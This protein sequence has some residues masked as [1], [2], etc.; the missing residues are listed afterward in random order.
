MDRI[1]HY[2]VMETLNWVAGHTDSSELVTINLSGQSLSNEILLG[3]IEDRLKQLDKNR[4]AICFEITETSAILDIQVTLRFMNRF[5][6]LGVFFAL[7]DFGSGLSS[8]GY[9]KGMPVD[10]IKIDGLFVKQMEKDARDASMVEAINRVAK[11]MDICTIAEH[12]QNDT[13]LSMLR[14]YGIDYAQGY[15]VAMPEKLSS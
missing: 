3:S 6:K 4:A 10:F 9:L 5:R 14:E 7:D 8:F 13:T 1:D 2:V 12:V 11:A 15:H